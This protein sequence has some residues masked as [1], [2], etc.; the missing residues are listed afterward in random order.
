MNVRPIRQAFEEGT[1]Q[2]AVLFETPEAILPW[3]N[4]TNGGPDFRTLEKVPLTFYL[5]DATA[6]EIQVMDGEGKTVWS[7]RLSGNKGFNQ[8]RWD[9]VIKR[10]DSPK[11]YFRDYRTFAEPGLY[12]IQISGDNIHLKGQVVIANRI[13]PQ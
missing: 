9:L 6:V 1:P 5:I 3:M 12:E 13:G 7:K 2:A 10:T 4:D 8:H 11:P